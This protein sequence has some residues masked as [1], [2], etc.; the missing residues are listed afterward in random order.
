MM[1]D[2]AGN[3]VIPESALTNTVRLA[4]YIPISMP[5]LKSVSINVRDENGNIIAVFSDQAYNNTVWTPIGENGGRWGEIIFTFFNPD[6]GQ[7]NQTF[8]LR[9]G[10]IVKPLK[11]KY[12]PK[13]VT[14]G[15][16]VLKDTNAVYYAIGPNEIRPAVIQLT[17]TR[18]M[19]VSFHA[20]TQLEW[21]TNCSY[22]AA[23]RPESTR[24]NFPL[25]P[26][27]PTTLRQL[28]AGTYFFSF[29]LPTF[30][31]KSPYINYNN[32]GGKG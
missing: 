19:D 29:D 9:D 4:D 23:L 30:G 12:A 24:K 20:W 17:L 8:S 13:F 21:A 10:T 27:T 18:D 7:W 6:R 16:I 5:D 22:R 3:P 1:L 25:V 14:E 32:D 2:K 31:K 11:K 15:L 28:K 26:G